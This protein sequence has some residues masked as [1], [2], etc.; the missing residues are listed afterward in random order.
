MK[1]Y[2]NSLLIKEE[3]EVIWF[4]PGNPCNNYA[5][6]MIAF[7]MFDTYGFP[8]EITEEIFNEKNLKIDVKGYDVLKRIQKEKGRC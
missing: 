4:V 6:A 5:S 7:S 2:F 8:V 3:N 1:T